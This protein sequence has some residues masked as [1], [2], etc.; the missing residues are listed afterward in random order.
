[1][2][3]AGVARESNP[4]ADQGGIGMVDRLSGSGEMRGSLTGR[5]LTC[6]LLI[7]SLLLLAP[8]S[9][10]A[11]NRAS[12]FTD[13]GTLTLATGGGVADLDPASIVTAAANV[14]VTANIDEGLVTYKGGNVGQF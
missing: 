8:R 11:Q 7:G 2:I 14:A 13:A 4:A 12:S 10:F 6:L 1:M 5:A 9:T 3:S